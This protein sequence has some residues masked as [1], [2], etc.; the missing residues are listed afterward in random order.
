MHVPFLSEQ[1]RLVWVSGNARTVPIR[2]CKLI[3][4]FLFFSCHNYGGRIN[5]NLSDYLLCQLSIIW[6]GYLAN[7][8]PTDYVRLITSSMH[9]RPQEFFRG[10]KSILGRAKI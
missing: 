7:V 1:E 2:Q 4:K 3:Q 10:S 6:L 8:T 5:S 9:G